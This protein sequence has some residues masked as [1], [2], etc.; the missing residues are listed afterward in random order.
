MKKKLV[1]LVTAA[2]MVFCLGALAGCGKSD[3]EVITELLASE[4]EA[5]KTLDEQYVA[6][7]AQSAGADALAAYG[8]DATDFV[9]NYLDGFDYEILGVA[10]DGDKA[11]ATCTVTV[12]SL[13]QFYDKFAAA[14]NKL[15]YN[16]LANLSEDK[17]NKKL[18][19]LVTKCLSD[20]TPQKS[21]EFSI[22]L[23]KDG[24]TW[25]YADGVDDVISEVLTAL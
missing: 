11:T 3:E 8:I 19:E 6:D 13:N 17:L 1:A 10:V 16:E 21:G 23:E 4:F 18:G 24:S 12:K 5:M 22:D 25:G 7:L 9:K 15:D 20:V 14:I 2:L